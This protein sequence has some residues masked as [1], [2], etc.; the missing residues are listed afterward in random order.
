[1]TQ[2]YHL[3]DRTDYA[4]YPGTLK[5]PVHYDGLTGSANSTYAEPGVH[6]Y[7]NPAKGSIL[8][9][10][11]TWPD[12]MAYAFGFDPVPGLSLADP[13]WWSDM[14]WYMNATL[15]STHPPASKITPGRRYW[16][17]NATFP[18]TYPRYN[19]P[20][21]NNLWNGAAWPAH[22]YGTLPSSWGDIPPG[23]N[24]PN[25]HNLRIM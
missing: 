22:L 14:S 19:V 15:N 7:A 23:R 25:L 24:V 18:A 6:A 10:A 9:Q 12:D 2:S 8:T 1:M 5:A 20:W 16:E 3:E 13:A 17:W 4:G 11:A 21:P